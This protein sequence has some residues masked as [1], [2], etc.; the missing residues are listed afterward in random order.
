MAD[1]WQK[2]TERLVLYFDVS[3]LFPSEI[4]ELIRRCRAIENQS[5]WTTHGQTYLGATIDKLTFEDGFVVS[6]KTSDVVLPEDK[7]KRQRK[8]RVR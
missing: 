5:N 2:T 3:R 1:N 7:P 8:A 6:C 4:H